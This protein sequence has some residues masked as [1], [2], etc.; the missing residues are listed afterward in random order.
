MKFKAKPLRSELFVPGNKEDWMRKAPR[1]GAD[2]LI[3]DLEDSVPPKEKAEATATNI[4]NSAVL[5]REA[6]IKKAKDDATMEVSKAHAKAKIHFES[7]KKD[8]E[9]ASFL[10]QLDALEK[11]IK[12]QTTLILDE[13]MGPF[14][15]LR[16]LKPYLKPGGNG[17][18]IKPE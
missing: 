1:Y 16:G 6:A 7:F 3:L 18:P 14:P 15:I 13:T 8:P 11:S 12:D 17:S 4:V 5:E 9:L 10:M 2:A